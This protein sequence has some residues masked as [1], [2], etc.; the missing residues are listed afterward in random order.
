MALLFL[1]L[2]ARA[3]SVPLQPLAQQVR[4]LE[5][6][7][8]YLG[9]PLS[10][11]EQ[12]LINNAIGNTDENAA[13]TELE[14]ILD[15]HVIAIVDINAEG[16]VKVE[17]GAAAPQIVEAGSRLFLVKVVNNGNVT[18]ELNVVSPNTG[19][20]YIQSNGNPEPPAKL[21]PRESAERWADISL[22]QR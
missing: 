2:S 21:T 7:L 15:R 1:A 16:R 11:A 13:V 22:Y 4:Q 3:A 18:A 12:Q 17:Q 8:N 10:T 5:E 6:A 20:V 14:T 9:Q 19:N